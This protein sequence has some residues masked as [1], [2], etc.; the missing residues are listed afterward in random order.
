M[1][2]LVKQKSYMLVFTNKQ[3][4][5]KNDN[6]LQKKNNKKINVDRVLYN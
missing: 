1:P 6:A 3:Q 2:L 4:R 5:K